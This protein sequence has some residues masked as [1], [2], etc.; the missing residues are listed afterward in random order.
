M[1]GVAVI[2]ILT[3]ARLIVPFGVLLYLGTLL[4]KRQDAV[5]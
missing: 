1:F 2:T 3:L 4:K 5:L